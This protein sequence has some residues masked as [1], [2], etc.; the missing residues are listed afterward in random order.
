[1]ETLIRLSGKQCRPRSD[2]PECYWKYTVQRVAVEES[3]QRKW[4][5]AQ[6]ALF[7]I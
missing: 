3:T 7:D 4:V 6:Y 1:M 5:K 2:A